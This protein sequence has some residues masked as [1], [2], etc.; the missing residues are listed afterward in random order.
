MSAAPKLGVYIHWAWCLSKCPYCDFNSFASDPLS[1]DQAAWRQALLA[2]LDHCLNQTDR[3]GIGS[4]FFGGGTPSLMAPATIE[5]V[6]T[7][8][9]KRRSLSKN[10]EVSL[11]ANPGTI[12]AKH[13]NALKLAGVNRLSI[14]VQSLEDQSLKRLGRGHDTSQALNA[15][16]L[17]QARFDRC[18][19]DLIYGRPGQTLMDWQAELEL[20]LKLG[21][22]HYSLYQ[23]T[24]NHGTPLGRAAE[25]G[26]VIALSSDEEADFYHLTVDQMADGGRSIYEIS[27]FAAKGQECRHNRDIWRGG[28]YLGIGPGAHGREVRRGEFYA[29]E[30]ISNPARWMEQV[31]VAGHGYKTAQPLLP[32]ERA[33][34]LVML[35]L[36]LTEGIGAKRFYNLTSFELLEV[37]DQHACA[38][39]VG[40]GFL[41]QSP[42]KLSV[43]PKGRLLLDSL[44]RILLTGSP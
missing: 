37:I 8:L 3:Q 6:L 28:A 38:R 20:A 43:T 41:R 12:D 24:Y 26:E 10:L 1:L 35:G 22:G 34:E 25:A 23:L 44:T 33:E 39:L 2:E 16:E 18:T 21:L 19:I 14:G 17:A 11:E 27:N 9:S 42:R 31:R 7:L 30:R 5:A 32:G 36:R 40:D 15:I 4:V 29:T 13:L